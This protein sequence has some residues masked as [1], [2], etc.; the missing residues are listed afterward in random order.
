MKD[1][2]GLNILI[3]HCENYSSGGGR[4]IQLVFSRAAGASRLES[5]Y[6]EDLSLST[7]GCYSVPILSTVVST[8]V[9]ST[10]VA[11]Q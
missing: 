4:T 5:M 8:V 6:G 1:R 2:I 3:N 10:V 7:P 9:C 11:P